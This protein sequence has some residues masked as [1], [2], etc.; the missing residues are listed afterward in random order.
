MQFA[1][2]LLFCLSRFS[3]LLFFFSFSSSESGSSCGTGIRGKIQGYALKG[4]RLS[5]HVKVADFLD[6]HGFSL[7]TFPMFYTVSV[8]FVSS[9]TLS[10]N[11]HDNVIILGIDFFFFFCVNWKY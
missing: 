8:M 7:V 3:V 4:K 2:L 1:F 11:A 5:G 6:I 10:D 9:L